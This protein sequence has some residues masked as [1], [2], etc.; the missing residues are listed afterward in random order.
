[1]LA[2]SLTQRLFRQLSRILICT[3]G[4]TLAAPTWAAA[5]ASELEVAHHDGVHSPC[6]DGDT[7]PCEDDCPC[8]CCPGHAFAVS[9]PQPAAFGSIAAV[10]NLRGPTSNGPPPAGVLPG[11]FRPPKG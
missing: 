3:T 5:T 7:G 1:M 2:P 10:S 9:L 8:L 4:L 11:V 6:P